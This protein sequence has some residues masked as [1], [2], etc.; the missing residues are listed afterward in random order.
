MSWAGHFR[1]TL[2]LGIP[3]V[4]SQIGLMLMNTTDTVMLGWYGIEEL[5]ASVLASQAYFIVMIF[6]AGF[7]QAVMPM[8]AQA[9]G[10]DDSRGVRRSVRMGLWVSLLYCLFAMPL[11]WRTETILLAF[12][13]DPGVAALAG[14]YMQIAMWAL[15]PTLLGHALRAFLSAIERAQIIFVTTLVA[16]A[17]NVGINWAL[18]FGNWGA[19]EMGIQ[20]A[21]IATLLV[22]L[23]M[24]AAMAVYAA[25]QKDAAHYELFVRFWRPDWPAFFD[26][27]RLGLPISI[28][29]LA[30]VGMFTASSL[31]MGWIGVV[32]L[33]AHGIAMQIS[34]IAFMVPLGMAQAATV[35]VGRAYGRRDPV[36]VSRAAAATSVLCAGFALAGA[37]LMWTMPELLIGLFLDKSEVGGVD[38]AVYAVPL[39]LVAAAF[40]LVDSAQVVGAGLLRGMKDTAIPMVIAI[41]SYWLAGLPLAYVLGIPAGLGGIGVWTGLAAGLALAAFA[42]NFRFL[43][44]RPRL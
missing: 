16:A 4:G 8:A 38:V 34:A 21:A 20:G 11:L 30:E 3:L 1:A 37:L 25:H 42:M 27:L 12:G 23:V 10:E 33:A 22:N 6:G 44:L 9:A 43:M 17:L 5:A 15:P 18:I 2:V 32:P 40:Q 7:S 31:I 36:G 41:A 29:I 28:T 19:P 35:R 26:V 14:Q 39:L 13:Q 24:F